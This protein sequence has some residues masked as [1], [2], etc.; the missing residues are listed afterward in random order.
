MGK[1]R[2]GGQ[3]ADLQRPLIPVWL[4]KCGANL[5]TG[6]QRAH[7][8]QRTKREVNCSS[9]KG[10]Q[11]LARKALLGKGQAASSD[12][13]SGEHHMS[14]RCEQSKVLRP[15]SQRRAVR[16]RREGGVPCRV[17]SARW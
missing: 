16:P 10:K 11:T 3:W 6:L 17:L 15:E 2:S 1:A 12:A 13:G 8:D 9:R 7:S 5:D 14:A 4:F